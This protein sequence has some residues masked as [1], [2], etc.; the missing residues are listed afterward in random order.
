MKRALMALACAAT[1][2][3]V[4]P[5]VAA[6]AHAQISTRAQTP[7]DPVAALRAQYATGHGVRYVASG[8]MSVAG[9]TA[10]T[11]TGNG[12]LAFGRSGLVASDSRQTI[13][14]SKLLKEENDNLKDA[15]KPLRAIVIGKTAYLS[16]GVWTS[17]LPEGKTWVRLPG[18]RPGSSTSLGEYVNPADLRNLKAVLATTKAKGPGGSVNGAKTT[19][20]R[21]TITLAQ[22][23]K[24]SPGIKDSFGGVGSNPAKTVV[25]WKLWIGADQLVRRASATADLPMK[26][27]NDSFTVTLSDVT[28]FAGWGRKVTVTAPPKSKVANLADLDGDVPDTQGT[29]VL[30]N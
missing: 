7:A 1:A 21:G 30:P 5:A 25:S 18:Q 13:K 19:L 27:D 22:L 9:V 28:T 23:M 14:Y 4:A 10:I 16:G 8:T 11:F 29:V 6:P 3:L 17:L 12:G 20:Y 26:V 24:V 15:E 2:A